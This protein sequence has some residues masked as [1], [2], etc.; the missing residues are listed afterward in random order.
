MPEVVS[1]K[2]LVRGPKFDYVEAEVRRAGTP[3]RVAG[4]GGSHRRVFIRHPGA[5]V[6]VPLL[7]DGRVVLIRNFRASVGAVIAELCAGTLEPGEDPA[8]TARRELIE[9]TG[10][11]AGT[12]T[13]L[14]SYLT[15]PGLSDEMM[16]AYLA[17][18]LSHVGQR[19]EEDEDIEVEPVTIDEA[20]AM[21]DDGRLNDAKSML[22][23][24]LARRKGLL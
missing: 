7:G 23:L 14:G 4:D 16:H 21:I 10:Y 6:I 3:G 19:L 15:S 2:V 12:M 13:R 17:T 22:A 8:L 18:G 9:E 5:V 20:F 24:L 11:N 1:T